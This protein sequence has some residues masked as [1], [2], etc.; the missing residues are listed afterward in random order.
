MAQLKFLQVPI[1]QSNR[2]LRIITFIRALFFTSQTLLLCI[3]ILLTFFDFWNVSNRGS[4]VWLP[5]ILNLFTCAILIFSIVSIKNEVEEANNWYTMTC[6]SLIFLLILYLFYISH[7]IPINKQNAYI[8]A[9]YSPYRDNWDELN[10]WYESHY[11]IP[12]DFPF[13]FWLGATI[14]GLAGP[15]ASQI[16]L[17]IVILLI[18]LLAFGA[19]LAF[20][21]PKFKPKR[22]SQMIYV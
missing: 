14:E 12:T 21:L 6:G 22:F 10:L 3:L 11:Q 15:P 20:N 5:L 7:I 18:L 9:P 16:V 13:A 1:E 4:M 8:F 2:E 19:V 17:A